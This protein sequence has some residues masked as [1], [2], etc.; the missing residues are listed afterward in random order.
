MLYFFV[1]WTGLLCVC[2]TVGCGLLHG[3]RADRLQPSSNRAILSAWLGLGTIAILLLAAAIFIP[4][5]PISGIGLSLLAMSMSLKSKAVR[6]EL[7]S[8]WN[9]MSRWAWL[10]Y[11]LCGGT[12]AAF[13]TQ[14]VTW[15]DTGL[16]H[17]GLVQWFAKYGVLPGLALINPQFGFISAWFA[18]AAPLNPTG[19]GGRASTAMNGFILLLT[20]LQIIIVIKEIN[21][22]KH[23]S[24]NHLNN[25]FLL[26]FSLLAFLLVTQTPLLSA[27]AIS[28]SPD[29]A[30]ILFSVMVAWTILLVDTTDTRQPSAAR[31]AD[32]IPVV[33]ATAAFSIKLTALPLLAATVG[34]Y[35][36]K[37]ISLK[38]IVTVTALLLTALF[39]FFTAQILSS[40][41]PLYPSTLAGVSLPWTRAPRAAN[42][43]AEATHGWGNWFNN[44]PPEVYRP[45]WLIQTWFH[46]THSSKLMTLC[47]GLSI[48]SAIILIVRLKTK[49]SHSIFWLLML[50]ILGITFTMLKAPLFRFGMGYFMLLPVLLA[51]LI[52]NRIGNRATIKLKSL[53]SAIAVVGILCAITLTDVSYSNLLSHLLLA[54]PLPSVTSHKQEMNGITY[55]VTQNSRSQCWSAQ[56]PC[57][58]YV[59]SKV[60]LRN[61]EIGIR[62]GFISD[63]AISEQS[64]QL[65]S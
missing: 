2:M 18:I 16:Y 6:Q 48:I 35:I 14:K 17:Y 22:K 10:C 36:F 20:V 41:Y 55:I 61:P 23:P 52:F 44:P 11:A 40:G 28:A 47:I 64:Q 29:I 39:P 51:A 34:F 37:S 27:I 12:I 7:A 15:I 56:L 60:N 46:S 8:W 4:L 45:A 59:R 38:R 63:E 43:L 50:A 26:I 57:V 3:L 31:S 5:S 1:V 19:L 9:Q 62:G 13:V 65:D 21:S 42:R 33:L 24:H 54:P 49:P 30:V 53:N 32:L 25:W 58:Y